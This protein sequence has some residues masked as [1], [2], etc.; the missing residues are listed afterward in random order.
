[1]ILLLFG[2]EKSF[3]S[4]DHFSSNIIKSRKHSKLSFL[5]NTEELYAFGSNTETYFRQF[6]SRYC[7]NEF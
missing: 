6:K 7:R 3:Q 5:V 1:M 4:F 2:K